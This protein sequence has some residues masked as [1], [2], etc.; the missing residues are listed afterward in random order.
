M[1][2]ALKRKLRSCF[3]Q[4]VCKGLLGNQK[5][6]ELEETVW[7]VGVARRTSDSEGWSFSSTAHETLTC[8]R[9]LR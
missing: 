4:L 7:N 2:C 3:L 8:A 9:K 6:N 1:L 5:S